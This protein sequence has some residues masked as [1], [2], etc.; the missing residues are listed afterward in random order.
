M[1][2]S[3]RNL[4]AGLASAAT[5]LL[6]AC[7][8][9]GGDGGGGGGGGNP[10]ATPPTAVARAAQPSAP[11]GSTVTLDGSAS[12]TPNGGSLSYEWTLAARPDGSTAALADAATARPSFVPDRPGNY[13]AA[14]VVKDA[15][16]SSAA[17]RVRIEATSLDPLAIITPASQ[18]VLLGATVTL[19]GSTSLAPTGADAAGLGYEW[20]LIEQPAGTGTL[21]RNASSAKASFTADKVG[22][23]RATLVASHGSRRSAAVQATVMVSTTNS[24]PVIVSTVPA[25]AVRGQ[26][27]VLDAGAS[28]DPDGHALHYRWHFARDLAG[29]VP[30]GSN[31]AIGNANSARASFVPDA[32]GTYYVDL[33]VYDGSVAATQRSIIKVAKPAGAANTAP[34]ARI[35]DVTFDAV[36]DLEFEAGAWASPSGARS[37]DI[38]GDTLTHQWTW[39]NVATPALKQTASGEHLN[40]GR[41]LAAGTYQ[42]ELVVNDGTVNS[43]KVSRRMVVKTGAN[44]APMAKVAVGD[45]P[46]GRVSDVLP[47]VM[48][49][50]TVQFDGSGSTDA[51]GDR[52]EYLWTLVDR[53]DGSNAVLQ[54]AGTASKA[55]AVLADQPGIYTVLLQLR[56]S[57]GLYSYTASSNAYASVLAKA[58]NNPPVIAK[59][60]LYDDMP[61]EPAADQPRILAE[62]GNFLSAT[63]QAFDPDQDAPL[64][65]LLS[66]TRQPAGSAAFAAAS[67]RIFSGATAPVGLGPVTVAGSYEVEAIVSDGLSPSEARRA[68]VTYV[69]RAQFPSLLIEETT[70]DVPQE[71]LSYQRFFPLTQYDAVTVTG[72]GFSANDARWFRLT[73]FDRDYTVT[74]LETR[75]AIGDRPS[76]KG[77]VNGQ[78]IRRG[79]SVIF[80]VERPRIADEA[81]LAERY[82]A[83]F[84][85]SF[86][87]GE[88]Q[89]AF[90]KE[91]ASQAALLASH[92][93]TWSFRLAEK[94]G[95]TFYIGPR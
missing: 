7:G 94:E 36:S 27:V 34:V 53:P 51:N 30:A 77:L 95:Y 20:K 67:E 90:D 54:N 86:N 64:H 65:Y 31:A 71:A 55:P 52:L 83:L 13:V 80:A 37:H 66:A 12:T 63:L 76:F 43:P 57:A 46:L 85:E 56:D 17:A 9:G 21:L 62:G 14:L 5:L 41:G 35:G 88:A 81:A 68:S 22:I 11:I 28:T 70:S 26:T 74:G 79:T 44:A 59:L 16:A 45:G 40:L 38:D 60:S 87:G 69:E 72:T 93:F 29:A 75:A 2:N 39:W 24:T 73:A 42:L 8:G 78:V 82:Q 47:K 50:E 58:A 3:L 18:G 6:A 19:D 10:A 61:V 91:A 23:Y 25:T 15:V 49:G 92:G 1:K 89:A 48:R 33:T 84:W 32:G 4:L